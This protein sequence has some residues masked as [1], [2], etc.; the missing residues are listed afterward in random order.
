ME[1]HSQ[2][3]SANARDI[4]L[5]GGFGYSF[6]AEIIGNQLHPHLYFRYYSV[7]SYASAEWMEDFSIVDSTD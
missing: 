1:N 7:D 3:V 2:V 6:Q 5:S 4:I